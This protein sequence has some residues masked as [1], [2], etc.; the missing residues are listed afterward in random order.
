MLHRLLRPACAELL[1][2]QPCVCWRD[3]LGN[4]LKPGDAF[5]LLSVCLR[6]KTKQI[7]GF[8]SQF[9]I[10]YNILNAPIAGSKNHEA[11]TFGFLRKKKIFIDNKNLKNDA[12]K[13]FV[14]FQHQPI[15]LNNY[16]IALGAEIF[17]ICETISTA[18]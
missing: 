12:M 9:F 1:C 14:M 18:I 4:G 11:F 17:I 3:V 7:P 15:E 10:F 5:C 16:M 6:S 8:T 13:C 2:P